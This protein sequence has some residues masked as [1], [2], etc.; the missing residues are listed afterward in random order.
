MEAFDRT[1]AVLVLTDDEIHPDNRVTLASDW[2][3]DEHGPVPQVQY[4]PTPESDRR[5]D[6][7]SRKAAGILRAA[8]ARS[9][10][11]ADFPPLYVH[12]QSSMRMGRDPATS[13]VDANQEAWEVARLFIADNSSLPDGLGGPNPTLTT[14]MFATR[15]AEY[16]ATQYFGRAPWVR[17]GGG[18][19]TPAGLD[20]KDL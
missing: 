7:L 9:V 16:I 12:I 8:G 3:E 17:E 14:Q 20:P 10:H 1:L 11:R 5:R 4:A 15:T 2:P 18:R 13:V 6:E 19:T